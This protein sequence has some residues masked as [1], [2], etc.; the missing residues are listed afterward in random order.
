MDIITPQSRPIDVVITD[1]HK[2]HPRKHLKW[3]T[4]DQTCN[5]LTSIIN[6]M[7]DKVSQISFIVP[8]APDYILPQDHCTIRFFLW[9]TFMVQLT[10]IVRNRRKVRTKRRKYPVRL[11]ALDIFV[12]LI[13]LSS[14]SHNW[15]EL[16]HESGPY[17]ESDSAVILGEDTIGRR[18]HDQ[19]DLRYFIRHEVY[20]RG[21]QVA[22]LIVCP[23]SQC[24]LGWILW[25]SVIRTSIGMDW[26]VIISTSDILIV[27]WLSS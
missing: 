4:H 2:I 6:P 17:K 8:L 27:A 16:T 23:P 9:A 10:S 19:W 15:C 14:V 22:C 25:R 5:L 18:W 11:R 26:G 20:N 21:Q 24:F 1:L 7:A 3:W 12:F 13:S